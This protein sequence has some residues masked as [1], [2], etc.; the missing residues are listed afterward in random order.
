M[1][2]VLHLCC[3]V[4]LA[5]AIPSANVQAKPAVQ[6]RCELAGIVVSAPKE[7]FTQMKNDGRPMIHFNFRVARLDKT[8][9]AAAKAYCR[10]LVG[11]QIEVYLGG[12]RLNE[13]PQGSTQI[14]RHDHN[15][16]KE[17]PYWPN[18]YYLKRDG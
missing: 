4:F 13:V 17:W 8:P 9:A 14:L 7:V 3:F 5:V 11:R 1:R 16:G 18:G 6:Q 2:R 10:S 15:S 12:A